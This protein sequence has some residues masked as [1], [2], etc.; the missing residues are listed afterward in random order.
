[1]KAK[2]EIKRK[3]FKK[4]KKKDEDILSSGSS[5]DENPK[6]NELTANEM[7]D[8][9]N[10]CTNVISFEEYLATIEF[11]FTFLEPRRENQ[12]EMSIFDLMPENGCVPLSKRHICYLYEYEIYGLEYNLLRK[13]MLTYMREK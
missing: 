6:I 3:L 4:Q 1:V 7:I 13:C 12:P 5:S 10:K 11:Q 8:F 2:K 9:L